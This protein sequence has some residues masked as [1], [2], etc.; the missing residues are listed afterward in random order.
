VDR[1]YYVKR[2]EKGTSL[3]QT[4]ATYKSETI[5]SAAYLATKYTETHFKNVFEKDESSQ[6]HRNTGY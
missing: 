5:D 4:E 6:P 2:K 1:L 3:L